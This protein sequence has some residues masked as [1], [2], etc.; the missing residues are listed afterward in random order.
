MFYALNLHS[1]VCQMYFNRKQNKTKS[2]YFCNEVSFDGSMLMERI[3]FVEILLV[4]V[5][6]VPIMYLYILVNMHIHT[7]TPNTHAIA[8]RPPTQY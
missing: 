2:L 3:P 1:I 5:S 6:Q 8:T 4:S 7:H